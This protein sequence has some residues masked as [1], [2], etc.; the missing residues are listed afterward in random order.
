MTTTGLGALRRPATGEA[1]RP[2]GLSLSGRCCS[3]P[4]S[5]LKTDPD[6][7]LLQEEQVAAETQVPSR[8]R[9]AAAAS[10][11][12]AA[13]LTL[14]CRLSSAPRLAETATAARVPGATAA[15]PETGATAPNRQVENGPGRALE[16]LGGLGGLALTARSCLG[17]GHHRSHR[18]RSHSKTPERSDGRPRPCRG[19]PDAPLASVSH[20]LAPLS[21][22]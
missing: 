3:E 5:L 15:A 21:L 9:R 18:H 4:L 2:D 20:L 10:P 17:P 22:L 7:L 13:R 8:A 11:R 1:A 19:R 12:F 16:G 14:F 6:S